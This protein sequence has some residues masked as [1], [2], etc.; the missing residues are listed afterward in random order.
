MYTSTVSS[1]S[2]LPTLVMKTIS[3]TT[4][5]II[6]ARQAPHKSLGSAT[7]KPLA[8]RK[9]LGQ[10]FPQNPSISEKLEEASWTDV[11]AWYASIARANSISTT[12]HKSEYIA[13]VR[14]GIDTITRLEKVYDYCLP[15]GP[16]ID[17]VHLKRFDQ[18]CRL[19][20]TPSSESS[21]TP[22]RP[23]TRPTPTR[24]G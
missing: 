17:P 23:S 16:F 21:G 11:D 2:S 13:S 8:T 14:D 3:S 24:C 6:V 5:S 18:T 12:D 10:I 15:I 7:K 9:P 1:S 20:A 22:S 4:A 19:S